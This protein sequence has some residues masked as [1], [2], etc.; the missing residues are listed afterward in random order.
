MSLKYNGKNIILAKNLRKNMTREEKR[1]WYDFLSDYSVRFQRQ[2]AI[3]EYIVDFYC[4]KAK[5]VIELDGSQHFTSHGYLEDKKRTQTLQTYGIRVLRFTNKQINENFCGVC[6]YIDLT[7][8]SILNSS[9][10]SLPL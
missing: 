5:L 10:G 4:H 6:E 9:L 3:D 2:K 7:V 8:K 1:L